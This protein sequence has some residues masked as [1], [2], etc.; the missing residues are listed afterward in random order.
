MWERS[1]KHGLKFLFFVAALF[2]NFENS[3]NI[4]LSFLHLLVTEQELDEV[5]SILSL[6]IILLV[7][8]LF[9]L[10]H[11]EFVLFGQQHG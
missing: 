1:I 10:L 8:F 3:S 9:V 7:K 11:D 5:F 2:N 6:R 4:T